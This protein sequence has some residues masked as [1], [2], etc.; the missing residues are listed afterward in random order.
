[1][2]SNEFKLVEEELQVT[3]PDAYKELMTRYPFQDSKYLLVKENLLNDPKTL[4]D[5]NRHYREN[6]Y[7]SKSLPEHS[8]II[9]KNGNNSIFFINL[10]NENQETVYYLDEERQ[11]NSNNL[12]K[13]VL[14][15]NFKEFV[16][17]TKILQDVLKNPK[18][19]IKKTSDWIISLRAL[20]S[21]EQTVSY[22]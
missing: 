12:D 6:G 11:Y 21:R 14:S 4:I 19:K 3:L 18:H 9:G 8:Y 2:V 1:M 5:L 17:L 7:K 10:N 22:Q 13:Y 20:F 16:E 15:S